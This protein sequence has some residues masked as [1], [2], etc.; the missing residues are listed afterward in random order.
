MYNPMLVKERYRF[1][2]L[3]KDVADYFPGERLA[4]DSRSLDEGQEVLMQ[5]F[6]N[7]HNAVL[8]FLTFHNVATSFEDNIAHLDDMIML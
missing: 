2:D 5:I 6:K 3:G 1:Q 8:P 4:L 7:K